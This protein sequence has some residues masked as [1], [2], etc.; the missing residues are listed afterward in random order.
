M[1]IHRLAVTTTTA[2]GVQLNL[3]GST[4]AGGELLGALG[5]G[6]LPALRRLH[7]WSATRVD[8]TALTALARGRA[9]PRRLE[10][11]ELALCRRVGSPG[12][13]ALAAAPFAR[14]LTSLNLAWLRQ[15]DDGALSA[16]TVKK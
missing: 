10:A 4:H 13:R 11:L 12:V 6:A 16:S 3:A 1:R 2:A 8:N 14:G 9:P 7:L 15:L 5:A